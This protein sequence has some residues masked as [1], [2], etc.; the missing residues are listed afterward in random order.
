[1]VK[2]QPDED[3]LIATLLHDVVEDTEA[4]VDDLDEFG[5]Q[6]IEMIDGL[7]KIS[8]SHTQDELE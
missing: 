7:T 6:V 8:E 5:P 3:T 4:T 1:M 2:H